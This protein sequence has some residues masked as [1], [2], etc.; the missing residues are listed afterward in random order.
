MPVNGQRSARS[1]RRRPQAPGPR[2]QQRRAMLKPALLR[3]PHAA[4]SGDPWHAL[5]ALQFSLL[6]RTGMLGVHA[7]CPSAGN[8]AKP[9]NHQI[10]P[11]VT[12]QM[13]SPWCVMIS[14]LMPS[15][16]AIACA[17]LRCH[18]KKNGNTNEAFP[19]YALRTTNTFFLLIY[20]PCV[21]WS[22]NKKQDFVV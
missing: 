22:G 14:W 19:S 13:G 3:H 1:R 15:S 7:H 9:P 20:T 21:F 5:L 6:Q 8:R 10:C 4:A 12:A 17:I 2:H 11:Y 18:T 16:C